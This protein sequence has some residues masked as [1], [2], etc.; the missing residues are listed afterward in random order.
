MQNITMANSSQTMPRNA[1]EIAEKKRATW[2][3]VCIALSFFVLNMY[4]GFLTANG[5]WATMMPSTGSKFETVLITAFTMGLVGWLVFTLVL[6]MIHFINLFHLYLISAPK[7]LFDTNFKFA[8]SIRN[9]LVG[10]VLFC[11]L[12]VPQYF[13]YSILVCLLGD[14]LFFVLFYIFL[15]KQF[16]P[17]YLRPSIFKRLAIYLF[18]YEIIIFISKFGGVWL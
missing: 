18:V 8:Y 4:Q 12:S 5:S 14:I 9:V 17:V 3:N 1:K 2:A 15:C 11:M 6:Y 16:Y 10:I 13:Y 7:S